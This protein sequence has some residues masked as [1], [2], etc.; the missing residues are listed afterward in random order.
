MIFNLKN[1]YL[2]II[3]FP[4]LFVFLISMG[5]SGFLITNDEVHEEYNKGFIETGDNKSNYENINL[6]FTKQYK[7]SD[8]ISPDIIS[9]ETNS[10]KSARLVASIDIKNNMSDSNYNKNIT[11]YFDVYN[12]AYPASKESP[13]MVNQESG[14][15]IYFENHRLFYN[16]DSNEN[17]SI[18]SSNYYMP[19]Y[20][21]VKTEKN[22]GNI[23]FDQ[24]EID[25]QMEIVKKLINPMNDHAVE[26]QKLTLQPG[27]DGNNYEG[28]SK[29][30]VVYA[31]RTT[32][33][34]TNYEYRYHWFYQI[35]NS[36]ELR[37]MDSS[38][39]K[40]GTQ[41]TTSLEWPTIYVNKVD[42][43]NQ[44]SNGRYNAFSIVYYTTFSAQNSTL[45][46]NLDQKRSNNTAGNDMY[47]DVVDLNKTL[48]S[49]S[50]YKEQ[51]LSYIQ[52]LFFV[53]NPTISN[54]VS[55]IITQED[56]TSNIN[57]QFPWFYLI[58]QRY[59]VTSGADIYYRNYHYFIFY[60][61]K[62]TDS[63]C[64]SYIDSGYLGSNYK[65]E[66]RPTV[67]S[68][69]N[70]VE[71]FSTTGGNITSSSSI[72]VSNRYARSYLTLGIS[73]FNNSAYSVTTSAIY[74]DGDYFNNVNKNKKQSDFNTDIL[75][76]YLL[77]TDSDHNNL[78]SGTSVEF[79]EIEST[80]FPYL[81]FIL[82][83]RKTSGNKYYYYKVNVFYYYT[84]DNSSNNSQIRLAKGTTVLSNVNDASANAEWFS[85]ETNEESVET[86]PSYISD[87][88]HK[89]GSYVKYKISY[90]DKNNQ[91]KSSS[92][93]LN[94]I[95]NTCGH[96]DENFNNLEER[97]KS[98]YNF[99]N[100]YGLFYEY[101]HDRIS[102][103]NSF[104]QQDIYNFSG[105]YFR[106]NIAS[107]TKFSGKYSFSNSLYNC[108]YSTA[109]ESANNK[110][111]FFANHF[112]DSNYDLISSEVI[113][114]TQKEYSRVK[115]L[116]SD[117]KDEKELYLQLVSQGNKPKFSA[118]RLFDRINSENITFDYSLLLKPKC[119]EINEKARE[120]LK[121]FTFD[122]T[123]KMIIVEEC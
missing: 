81:K 27:K 56:E 50:I 116:F 95:S 46:I 30:F 42:N 33:D 8:L 96:K 62:L 108:L 102:N 97:N 88:Y 23:A 87:S 107:V 98:L 101:D 60:F 74:F 110:S 61:N 79:K 16:G 67:F 119:S 83:R 13:Y 77:T 75:K 86:N 9:S 80:N 11:E 45:T 100:S 6:N 1:R 3:V 92:F 43:S 93:T 14:E 10:K 85:I 37:R 123:I 2:K 52:N 48:D 109:S 26:I 5:F 64:L 103:F 47:Y 114:I 122:L 28:Y 66:E 112:I 90:Y 91:L 89:D 115:Y 40:S 29:S 82:S 4:T 15:D 25:R 20:D 35:K 69:S 32:K 39:G 72:S 65:S 106:K 57:N 120:I 76:N 51:M 49:F 121:C 34:G 68:L 63:L 21:L 117:G 17:L 41:N 54:S 44:A 105:F 31:S 99:T 7:K 113:N 12:S 70:N 78:S 58:G 59:K 111:T 22:D 19:T 104:L 73:Y 36:S 55:E 38:T 24:A 94:L 84:D 71:T 18:E 53:K 118:K